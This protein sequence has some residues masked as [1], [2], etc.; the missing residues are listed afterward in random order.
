MGA[1]L[2]RPCAAWSVFPARSNVS[3]R[4]PAFLY[5]FSFFLVF[6]VFP[7]NE[8]LDR[9][10]ARFLLWIRMRLFGQIT[11]VVG[12]ITGQSDKLRA[13]STALFGQITGAVHRFLPLDRSFSRTNYGSVGHDAR[14]NRLITRSVG[15]FGQITG[16]IHRRFGQ[17]TGAIHR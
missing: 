4:V 7:K 15:A 17:I 10:D 2:G 13:L 5:S 11:G 8:A 3:S 16:A 14:I 9:M 12:Q 1:L 6:S